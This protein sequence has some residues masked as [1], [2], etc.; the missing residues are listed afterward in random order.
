MTNLPPRTL[1]RIDEREAAFFERHGMLPLE[2]TQERL[3]V[4]VVGEPCPALLDE[5]AAAYGATVVPVPVTREELGR[6]ILRSLWPISQRSWTVT[7]A[8]SSTS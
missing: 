3:L 8:A 7:A 6:A 1:P 2:I 4:A 5:L